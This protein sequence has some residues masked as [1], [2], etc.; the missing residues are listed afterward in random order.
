MLNPLSLFFLFF[1]PELRAEAGDYFNNIT[2]FPH[3]SSKQRSWSSS[4]SW[5]SSTQPDRWGYY[6]SSPSSYWDSSTIAPSNSK[7]K[8]YVDTRISSGVSEAL[9]HM[10]AR[11][12]HMFTRVFQWQ[13]LHLETCGLEAKAEK[14]LE[15]SLECNN[16][17]AAC[18]SNTTRTNSPQKHVAEDCIYMN[19]YGDAKC[20]KSNPRCKVLFYIHG[21]GFAYDSA[22]MF[23][24]TQIVQNMP[25][26]EWFFLSNLGLHDIIYALEWTKR[27]VKAFGGDPDEITIMGA[28]ISVAGG[29]AVDYLMLSP[30]V[31]K[32][33]FK[34]AIV[35]SGVPFFKADAN[36]PQSLSIMTRFKCLYNETSNRMY[37]DHQKVHCL[38]NVSA[39]DLIAEQ[40]NSEAKGLYFAGP[41]Q[42]TDLLPA[43]S[44]VE[45]LPTFK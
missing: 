27:E 38:R 9:S 11:V 10:Q 2:A 34:Q 20:K 40:Q 14:A 24:E 23:N 32:I 13:S 21:G 25:L 16:Y 45:L 39:Q 22:V 15:H 30:K 43:A 44:F 3:S 37:S 31:P 7:V 1:V 36:M 29:S 4:S 17:S 8:H 35:S 28:G 42:D 26:M 19:I 33:L 12:Q 5:S 6:S 41:E 18:L